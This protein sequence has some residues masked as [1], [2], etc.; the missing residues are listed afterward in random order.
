MI[1]KGRSEGHERNGNIVLVDQEKGSL[2]VYVML[3][4]GEYKR[5]NGIYVL[6]IIRLTDVYVWGLLP[7]EPE[8]TR[9]NQM[10]SLCS[11]S[12][13]GLTNEL[14]APQKGSTHVASLVE[15]NVRSRSLVS[16]KEIDGLSGQYEPRVIHLIFEFI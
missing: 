9:L 11:P 3:S 8:Q 15:L 14:Y 6:M 4:L 16:C 2:S 7:C 5:A 10:A 12:P 13:R 1:P